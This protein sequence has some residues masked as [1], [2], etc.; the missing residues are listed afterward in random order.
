LAAAALLAAAAIGPAQAETTINVLYVAPDVWGNVHQDIKKQFEALHPDIKIVYNSQY[1]D[2]EAALQGLFRGA[3]TGQLPDVTY[4]GYNRI[5]A[6]SD[7]GLAVDLAPFI[8]AEKDW[9]KMGYDES[10][11]SLGQVQGKQYG[12]AWAISTPVVFYNATLV[13]KAGVDPDNVPKTWDGLFEL[14]R[15]IDNPDEKIRGLKLDWDITGNWMWQA[16][17]FS[18]GGAMLTPDEK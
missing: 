10:L 5:R 9:S 7:R 13:K 4:I 12:L 3:I 14:A 15:K 2:F 18:Y 6:L 1:K 11:M 17:V 8:K 16:L